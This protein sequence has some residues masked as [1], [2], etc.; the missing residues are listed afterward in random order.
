MIHLTWRI[1][2]AG[3]SNLGLA[4]AEQGLVLGR[5]LLVQWRE[6]RFV[7]RE[8]HEIAQLLRKAYP[9]ELPLERLMHGLGNVAAALNAN[10][11]CLAHL[12][13]VHLEIPNLP[14]EVARAAMEAADILI[15]SADWNPALHPR[16]G[17]SPNPGWFAA[18]E[19]SND[20]QSHSG[21]AQNG[22]ERQSSAILAANNQ[23]ENKQVRDI[24]TQLGL[25]RSQRQ[26]LHREISGMGYNYHQNL[27]IAKDMFGK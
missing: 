22:G 12:A 20:G 16:T 1:G 19:G 23:Q 18:T 25:N 8:R 2:E 7:V 21:S 4:F 6:G 10:D 15:K 14:D 26:A 11:P 17:T 5:T 3:D 27:E 24:A 13:A 9:A